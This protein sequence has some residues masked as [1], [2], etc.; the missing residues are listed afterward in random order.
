MKIFSDFMKLYNKKA[1]FIQF[2][3]NVGKKQNAKMPQ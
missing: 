3:K 1:L 2:Y